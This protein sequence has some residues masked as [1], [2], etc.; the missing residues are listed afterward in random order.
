MLP[1]ENDD[2]REKF[3]HKKFLGTKQGRLHSFGWKKNKKVSL[4]VIKPTSRTEKLLLLVI[5]NTVSLFEQ[6]QL[7]ARETLEPKL[8]NSLKKLSFTL[9]V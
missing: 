7:K 4:D 5:K 9:P 8:T 1:L 3:S 6:T 2:L